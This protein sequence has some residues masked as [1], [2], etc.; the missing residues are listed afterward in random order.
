MEQ[1]KLTIDRPHNDI[2]IEIIR[3]FFD[4]YYE[5]INKIY[6]YIKE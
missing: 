4:N 3:G 2:K 1:L 5:T 6:N